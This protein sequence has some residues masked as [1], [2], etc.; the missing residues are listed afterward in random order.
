MQLKNS[1]ISSTVYTLYFI[2]D[3]AKKTWNKIKLKK[4]KRK[5]TC[6]SGILAA[7]SEKC[8]LSFLGLCW[9]GNLKENF[10]LRVGLEGVRGEWPEAPWFCEWLPVPAA[11]ALTSWCSRSVIER[12]VNSCA[13]AIAEYNVFWSAADIGLTYEVFV[14]FF[15]FLVIDF[16]VV[17]SISSEEVMIFCYIWV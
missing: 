11:E 7:S 13:I 12:A 17:F 16:S 6:M 2:V 5:C 15:F 3:T 4:K 14:G 8:R 10:R 1:T 9:C